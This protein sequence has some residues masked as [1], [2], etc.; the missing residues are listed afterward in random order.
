MNR[1]RFASSN[2]P[3]RWASA[4]SCKATSAAAC[5][6]KSCGA[7][8]CWTCRT[9]RAKGSFRSSRSVE[10]WYL[11]ISFSA[12]SPGRS[13]CFRFVGVFFLAGVPAPVSP[14]MRG[15]VLRYEAAACP[16]MP[17]RWRYARRA[18]V[19]LGRA[20]WPTSLAR[21]SGR[22]RAFCF[23][24]RL[25]PLRALW[26]LCLCVALFRCGAGQLAVGTATMNDS[27]LTPAGPRFCGCARQ[28]QL[29]S[30]KPALGP[31]CSPRVPT[32]PGAL[33]R[34]TGG[35][36]GPTRRDSRLPSIAARQ[37]IAL[38]QGQPP[39]DASRQRA[40]V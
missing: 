39:A 27:V 18:R 22:R 38:K 31:F 21:S 36:R 35:V 19:L 16:A 30:A 2:N 29:L 20:L 26:P 6:R 32:R 34:E 40:S 1:T 15:V 23:G 24:E 9:S 10:R 14:P 8:P 3:T 28:V 37:A 13:R 33:E 25:A 4:A 11:R 5:Q 17:R 12:A 7:R